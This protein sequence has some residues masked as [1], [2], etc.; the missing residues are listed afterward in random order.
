MVD[1]GSQAMLLDAMEMIAVPIATDFHKTKLRKSRAQLRER[2]QQKIDTLAWDAAAHMQQEWPTGQLGQDGVG[3][4]I[5]LGP[6]VEL[7]RETE[8]RLNQFVRIDQPE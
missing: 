8:W 6:F 3:D 1:G 4:R 7:W 2:A 5:A